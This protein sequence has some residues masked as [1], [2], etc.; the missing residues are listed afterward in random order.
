MQLLGD[1]A[2][3]NRVP[4]E[5]L[6]RVFELGVHE[7]HNV[8]L[9]WSLVSKYWHQLL[10]ET[11]TLWTYVKLDHEWNYGRGAEFLRKL[12][13]YLT[14][15]QASKL[16]IDLDFR[17]CES[18]EEAK[19]IMETVNPH[20]DRCFYFRASVP[21]WEWMKVVRDSCQ[22][23]GASLEEICL[24]ID[25]LDSDDTTPVTLLTGT[26]PRLK[27]I[28]LEQAPLACIRAEVPALTRFNL[29]RDNRYHSSCIRLSLK[30]VIN[31]ITSAPELTD[32]KLQSAVFYLDGSEAIFHKVPEL[33]VLSNLTN[34]AIAYID[35]PNMNLFFDT[36]TFPVLHSLSVQLE[37][38]SG[39]DNGMGWLAGMALRCSCRMPSLR[40]LELRHCSVDSASLVPFVNALHAL[41]QITT[42][43]L[44]ASPNGTIGT[45]LFDL[46]AGGPAVTGCWLLP[47]LEALSVLSCR[48]V[49]GHELLR[50]LEA[51]QGVAPGKREVNDI[52]VLRVAPS[53]QLDRDIVEALRLNVELLVII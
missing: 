32:V 3:I 28:V 14:R 4:S 43:C 18:L 12:R 37:S 5:I 6:A 25:P 29:V 24:R 8:L 22:T 17:Y 44:S 1:H 41:P 35:A 31:T 33:V 45:K 26:L 52:R 50:L 2:L 53:Y 47:R 23:L 9:T 48:D 21:D 11:P 39:S 13:V 15:S 40:Q 30:D 34:L 36:C 16:S 49:S 38:G 27:S 20:L 10:L 46:L 7:N 51:R 19:S 42:L